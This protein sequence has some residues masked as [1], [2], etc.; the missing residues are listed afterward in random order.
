[1]AF[2]NTNDYCYSIHT[3]LARMPC[4]G[5]YSRFGTV[6]ASRLL[7]DPKA[8]LYAFARIPRVQATVQTST[9]GRRLLTS[10]KFK[11]ATTVD[12]DVLGVSDVSINSMIGLSKYMLFNRNDFDCRSAKPN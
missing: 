9:C 1:M 8:L 5:K 6:D 11:H 2:I 7:C 10:Q 3:Y 4:S 12:L